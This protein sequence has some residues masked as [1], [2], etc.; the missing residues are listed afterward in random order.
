MKFGLLITGTDTGVGKTMVGCAL[1][2]AFRARGLRVGVM[3]PAETGCDERNGTLEAADA[4]A[5]AFASGCELPMETICP[6]RYR[7][8]LA[9][10][11][12]AQV[13]SLPVPDLGRITDCFD[14]IAAASDIVLVEGAG[15]IAVP[16][17]WS[18]DFADVAAALHLDLIVVIANRLGCLNSALLT[19]RYAASKGLRVAGWILNDVEPPTTLAALTNGNS[20]AHLTEVPCLGVVRFKEPLGLAVVEKLLVRNQG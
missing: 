20:L 5:L 14:R 10:A 16:L 6:Y 15:G 7:S 3:K 2:F 4:R 8:A 9:P 12:A 17:T 18:I 11:A 1:G 19:F 13:D